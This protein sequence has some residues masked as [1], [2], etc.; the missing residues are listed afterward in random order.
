MPSPS[1]TAA[2]EPFDLGRDSEPS[3]VLHRASEPDR[4]EVGGL[5]GASILGGVSFDDTTWHQPPPQDAIVVAR[6]ETLTVGSFFGD[7]FPICIGSAKVDSALF[8]PLAAAPQPPGPVRLA[9]SGAG[10]LPASGFR[11]NAPLDPGEWVVRIS[12]VFET[13]P[14]PSRQETF[15]RLRV[16]VP[17]PKVE[18]GATAPVACGRAGDRPP[19]AYLSVDGRPWVRAEG[20]SFSWRGISGD[21]SPPVGPLVEAAGDAHLRIRIEDNVCAARWR[22]QL[23]PRPLSEFG[24]QEPISDLVP[25]RLDANDLPLGKANRFQLAAIPPGD[26]VVRA[27]FVFGTSPAETFGDTSSFWNVVVR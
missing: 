11:F 2:C 20:G 5:N 24:Y 10:D 1:A 8:S 3:V 14:G 19:R 23:A 15:F 25:D 4:N 22:I 6:G 13:T 16:D 17:P 18:G 26:W 21:A 7:G 27:L 12:L 9:T